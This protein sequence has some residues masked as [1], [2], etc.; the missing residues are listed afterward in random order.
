MKKK[1]APSQRVLARA[2]AKRKVEASQNVLQRVFSES[3]LEKASR[4]GVDAWFKKTVIDA[5]KKWHVHE[6]GS[7]PQARIVGD[8]DLSDSQSDL[9]KSLGTVKPSGGTAP[10]GGY[11]AKK[12]GA[13]AGTT[14]GVSYKMGAEEKGSAEIKYTS[15]GAGGG[16]KGTGA[17]G[18]A[19][20]QGATGQY[21]K[22]HGANV[23]CSCGMVAH[24]GMQNNGKVGFSPIGNT[25]SDS[26]MYSMYQSGGQQ[27]GDDSGSDLYKSGGGG[28]SYTA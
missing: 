8:E 27:Q 23:Q 14:A 1:V 9:E 16:Y 20:Q 18:G 7:V 13:K 5:F 6:D 21:S 17:A 15:T 22:E 19:Y 11:D 28:A 2:F 26:G 12:D 24:A 25:K 4:E 3:G 10:A